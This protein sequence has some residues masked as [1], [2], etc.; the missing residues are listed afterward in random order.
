LVYVKD[1]NESVANSAT[2]QDDNDFTGIPLT[3]DK[4]YALEAFFIIG[5]TVADFDYNFVFTNT[6]QVGSRAFKAIDEGATGA[7]GNSGITTE[8]RITIDHG[9]GSHVQIFAR[10]HANAT[11]GGT[12]KVQWAQS[13]GDAASTTLNE[14]S[15]LRLTQLD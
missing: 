1:A 8:D 12:F 4:R 11:T 5:S 3:A 10:I 2:L 7:E 14:G 6:P 13:A 15:W 9:D